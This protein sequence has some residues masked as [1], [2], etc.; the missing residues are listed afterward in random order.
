MMKKLLVMPWKG[1]PLVMQGR[2]NQVTNEEIHPQVIPLHPHKNM[3]KIK[4]RIKTM[5]IKIKFKRR[6]MIKGEM[7]MMGM[8]MEATQNLHHHIQECTTPFKE[9][10]PWITSLVISRTG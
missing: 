8:R 7:R 6:A 4:K 5:N 2:K 1:C 3:I 10:I 9:I